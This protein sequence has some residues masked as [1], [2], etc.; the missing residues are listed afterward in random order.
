MEFFLKDSI[1]IILKTLLPTLTQTEEK[2][3]TLP[4]DRGKVDYQAVTPP[5]QGGVR[6]GS[7]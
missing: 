5:V 1:F 3:V 2:L 6:G 4:E 7:H